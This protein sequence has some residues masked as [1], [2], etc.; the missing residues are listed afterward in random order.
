ME[1]LCQQAIIHQVFAVQVLTHFYF[2]HVLQRAS[3]FL[4]ASSSTLILHKPPLIQSTSGYTSTHG[5]D[6]AALALTER[7]RQASNTEVWTRL[8]TSFSTM[9]VRVNMA[10]IWFVFVGHDSILN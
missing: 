8:F 2:C 1:S 10:T 7:Q 5:P 9:S 6:M 4:K 3:S